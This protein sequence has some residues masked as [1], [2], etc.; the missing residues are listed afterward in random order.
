MPQPFIPEG[1]PRP[2]QATDSRFSLALGSIGSKDFYT[3]HPTGR[4]RGVLYPR[5]EETKQ[6]EIRERLLHSGLILGKLKTSPDSE[7]QVFTIPA[8]SRP[9]AYDSESADHGYLSYTDRKL[10]ADIG[11]L[12]ARLSMIDE[13]QPRI[14]TEPIGRT[15]A[16]V[17]F[18]KIGER[19]TFLIPGVERLLEPANPE[20]PNQKYYN[21]L[22]EEEFGDRFLQNQAYFNDY[23]A[24][25]AE[26]VTRYGH[27]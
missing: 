3:Q 6:Q 10:F 12:L 13:F 11:D 18:A 21:L 5:A 17:E 8:S 9:L 26:E 14:S 23:Y 15:I 27:E 20:Q 16:L 2:E 1:L 19:G 22:L 25:A 24:Q 4:V 7:T